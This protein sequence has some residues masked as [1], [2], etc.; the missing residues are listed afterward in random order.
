MYRV[1]AMYG[2]SDGEVVCVNNASVVE[3]LSK[4]YAACVYAIRASKAAALLIALIQ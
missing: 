2:G 1:R 3:P 4:I